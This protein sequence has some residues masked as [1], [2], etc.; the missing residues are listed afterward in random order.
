MDVDAEDEKIADLHVDFFPRESNGTSVGNGSWD[1]FTGFDGGVDELFEKG[2]LK[3][4]V[5]ESQFV[6]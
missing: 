5:I 3:V 2:R 4:S 1:V 6:H